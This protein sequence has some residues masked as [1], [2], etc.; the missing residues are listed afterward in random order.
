[1]TDTGDLVF[2]LTENVGVIVSAGLSVDSTG[3]ATVDASI[4]ATVFKFIGGEV[5]DCGEGFFYD[6]ICPPWV[7]F[8]IIFVYAI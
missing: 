1:M 5:T 3:M 6:V 4:L 2:S 7:Y 8:S